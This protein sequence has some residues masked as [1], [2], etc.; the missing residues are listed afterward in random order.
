MSEMLD[1]IESAIALIPEL[2]DMP[3]VWE[4]SVGVPF[5]DQ[6]TKFPYISVSNDRPSVEL[7]NSNGEF[8]VAYPVSICIRYTSTETKQSKSRESELMSYETLGRRIAHKIGV[9]HSDGL[10]SCEIQEDSISQ[11]ASSGSSTNVIEVTTTFTL[12]FDEGEV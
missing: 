8:R 5:G 3:I 10:T 12:A 7:A 9:L 4:D 11:R 1:T 2:A 6:A